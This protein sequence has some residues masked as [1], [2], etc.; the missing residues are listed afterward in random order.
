M[1]LEVTLSE[2][3]SYLG[4]PRAWRVTKPGSAVGGGHA[5]YRAH[6]SQDGQVAV[7]VL[8]PHFA[9]TLCAPSGVA[10]KDMAALF[11]L[12]THEGVAAFFLTQTFGQLDQLGADQDIPLH[13]MAD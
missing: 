10:M 4:Q 11:A 12:R 13:A 7:V 9:A 2:S 6:P 8:K 1:F 5:G 3:A